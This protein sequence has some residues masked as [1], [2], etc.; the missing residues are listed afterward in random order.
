MKSSNTSTSNTSTSNTS[1]SKST[2]SLNSKFRSSACDDKMSFQDC[3]LAIVRQAVDVADNIRKKQVVKDDE[4]QKIITILEDFLVKK[5][6]VCYGGT[7]INNILPSQAQFYDRELEIPDYDFYSPD[8]MDDAI[9]LADI[10]FKHGYTD[11]EAKAGVHHGTYKVFVNFI[12]IADITLLHNLLFDKIRSKAIVIHGIHYSPPDFLRMNMYLELSR[13]MGDVSRWEKVMK[14][15]T[16]LNKHYPMDP[17]I[18]CDAITFQRDIKSVRDDGSKIYD[19]TLQNLVK[20][21]VVFFGGYGASLYSRHMNGNGSITRK[22][23]DFDVLANEP[24]KCANLLRE[25][26]IYHGFKN[27]VVR[28]QEGLHE[29]IPEHH[30]VSVNGNQVAFLYKPIACHSY[31]SIRIAGNRIKVATIDTILNFYLAFMYTDLPYYNYQRLLCMAKYL[32]D[33]QI[34]NRLSQKGL[35]R[36]FSISCY[37]KQPTLE[38]MRAEKAAQHKKLKNMRDSREYQ[39]W[40]LK[41]TPGELR[42]SRVKTIKKTTKRNKTQ[43]KR[44]KTPSI[45]SMVRQIINPFSNISL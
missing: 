21:G 26:L 15:I 42:S 7:A 25:N 29:V 20:F 8:A 34:R 35:L 33:V 1:T 36:R 37:G 9:E 44:T 3:E 31:N 14:R 24:S 23:P 4:I 19:I 27:V 16:L 6:L 43:R 17:T 13:P 32:Y 38:E 5:K 45:S 40:F 18:Q 28:K 10:Y 41:Y 22:T 30:I 11:V 39:S 2:I 12:P